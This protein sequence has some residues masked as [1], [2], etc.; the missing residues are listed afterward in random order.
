MFKRLFERWGRRGLGR[1][2]GRGRMGGAKAGAGPGG[3]CICPNCGH[4]APHQLGAPCYQMSCP[5]CSTN[6]ARE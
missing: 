3:Y 1:G 4:K 5:K 6:M 2:G